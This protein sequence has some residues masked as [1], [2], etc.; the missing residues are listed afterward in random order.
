M[1]RECKVLSANWLPLQTHTHTH[2]HTHART[3]YPFL[4]LFFKKKRGVSW[5]Y[6]LGY[7]RPQVGMVLVLSKYACADLDLVPQ[8]QDHY[9]H[10]Y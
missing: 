7:V 1:P 3:Y 8:M 4:L 9:C 5:V 6:F 10:H 2:T